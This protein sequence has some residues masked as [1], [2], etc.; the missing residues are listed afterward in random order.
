MNGERKLRIVILTG[1][2]PHHKY[3][4]LNL[5]KNFEVLGVFTSSG[6][7]YGFKDKINKLVKEIKASGVMYT[8]MRWSGKKVGTPIKH[9]Y[10]VEE[11]V[12]FPDVDHRFARELAELVSNVDDIN[13]EATISKISGLFPDVVVCLGGVIYSRRLIESVP[14]ML[15]WHSGISPIY[16]GACSGEFAFAN[17]HPN[18]TGGTLMVIN[19]KVDGGDILAHYFTDIERGDTPAK[20]F[21]KTVRAA[22][23]V[24]TR[25]LNYLKDN[26]PYVAVEQTPAVFNTTTSDW[27][28]Y[29]SLKVRKMIRDQL[30]D[31]YV[32]PAKTVCYW[33]EPDK[34]TAQKKLNNTIKH[35]FLNIPK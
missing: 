3:F 25:F 31:K 24:Y 2:L 20:L 28:I 1:S 23:N 33:N 30:I 34:E 6:K 9:N 16:N 13:S 26:K 15:N 5:A 32:R 29:H 27:T 4:C 35:V 8:A 12:Y 21:I 7:S 22:P 19:P 17:G 10:I 11:K 14:L 18:L